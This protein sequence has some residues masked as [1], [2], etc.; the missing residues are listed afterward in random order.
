MVYLIVGHSYGTNT[1]YSL[2]GAPVPPETKK[3]TALMLLPFAGAHKPRVS[4]PPPWG[5]GLSAGRDGAFPW[6]CVKGY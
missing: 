5:L 6:G 2:Y 3:S 1:M 4:P